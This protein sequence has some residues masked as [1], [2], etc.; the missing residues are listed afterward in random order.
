MWR[1][2]LTNVIFPGSGQRTEL[3]SHFLGWVGFDRYIIPGV[4]P[5]LFFLQFAEKVEHAGK[6]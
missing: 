5:A 6:G 2:T 1:K 3:N 4:I